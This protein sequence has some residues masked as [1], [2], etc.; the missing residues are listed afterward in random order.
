M[1]TNNSSVYLDF[2][3]RLLVFSLI[4][5]SFAALLFFLLPSEFITPALPFLFPFFISVT[6]LSSYMLTRS[7]RKKFIKFLNAYLLLTI[8]KL[9]VYIVV[10]VGYILMHRQDA[11]PFGISFFLLYLF[12][13]IFE[14]VYLVSSFKKA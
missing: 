11:L 5:G 6:L 7:M 12:Y 10:M 4:L 3:K 1:E 8:V 9:F 2:L 13:T 14:V